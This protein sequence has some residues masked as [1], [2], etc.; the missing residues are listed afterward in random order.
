VHIETLERRSEALTRQR[1]VLLESL[2]RAEREMASSSGGG[3]G[4]RVPDGEG[5]PVERWEEKAEDG[6][7]EEGFG[8]E[9]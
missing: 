7:K 1:E 3:D 9:S 4:R 6:V 5:A 2:G 8:E